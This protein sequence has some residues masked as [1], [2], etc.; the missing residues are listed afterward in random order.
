MGVHQTQVF[1]PS[2]LGFGESVELHLIG[3]IVVRI[4]IHDVPRRVVVV[5][6]VRRFGYVPRTGSADEV[7]VLGKVDHM[8]PGSLRVVGRVIVVAAQ[9]GV[10]RCGLTAESTEIVICL[11]PAGLPVRM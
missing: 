4:D 5:L 1:R 11:L 8:Q 2:A 7:P 6:V 10:G 3:S 9:Q